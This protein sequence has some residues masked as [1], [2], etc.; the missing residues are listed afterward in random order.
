MSRK[1]EFASDIEP[2][3]PVAQ[4]SVNANASL[5]RD[6]GGAMKHKNRSAWILLSVLLASC[7]GNNGRGGNDPPA[8][9][10]FFQLNATAS[11]AENNLTVDCELGFIVEVSGEVSRTP[12]VVE[13]IAT[14]GGDARRKLLRS[15]GSGV[16]F[17]ANSFYP[18]LQVLHLLPNRVQLISLDF[19]PDGPSTGSRFWDELR[20]F[21]GFIDA[22]GVIEGEWLCAPLDTEQGGITDDTIFAEG[23][24]QTIEIVN[25]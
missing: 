10:L 22:N 3:E 21:D 19:P 1:D 14:M 4:D 2:H 20:F 11:T 25:R 9:P 13:Y 18:R 24:W 7:D 5:P 17:W 23:K 12:E 6:G 16:D 8:L 15:D